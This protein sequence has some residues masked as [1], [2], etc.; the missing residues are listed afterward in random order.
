MLSKQRGLAAILDLSTFLNVAKMQPKKCGSSND[1]R[2]NRAQLMYE[3]EKNKKKVQSVRG[4]G[5]HLGFSP[6]S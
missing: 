3:L 6:F 4:N 5:R 1:N 2:I